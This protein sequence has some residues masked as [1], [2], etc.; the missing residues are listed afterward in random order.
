MESS[1]EWFY[2]LKHNINGKSAFQ[3]FLNEVN[4]SY[5]INVLLASA[6]R[7]GFNDRPTS[8]D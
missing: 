8:F 1:A 7:R 3:I 5:F 2:M 6:S 4:D